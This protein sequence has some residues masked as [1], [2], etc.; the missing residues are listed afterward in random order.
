MSLAAASNASLSIQA[1]LYTRFEDKE[2]YVVATADPPDALGEQ[3]FK[4]IGYH[5]LP[6]KDVCGRVITLFLDNYRVVGVPVYIEGSQYSR[7]AFIFCICFVIDSLVV[8]ADMGLYRRLA[9]QLA[10]AFSALERDQELRFLSDDKHLPKVNETLVELRRQLNDP[11]STHVFVSIADSHSICFK[12]L[13]RPPIKKNV[14]E[15]K[16]YHVPYLLIDPATISAEVSA[17]VDALAIS[18]L[19]FIDGASCV[20]D[21]FGKFPFTS[22]SAVSIA[23]RLLAGLGS[24]F[25]LPPVDEFSRFCLTPEAATFFAG[26]LSDRAE[27]SDF[28]GVSAHEVARS[29]AKLKGQTFSAF[30][31]Q[32]AGKPRKL[33]IFGLIKNLVRAKNM[34]PYCVS[35]GSEILSA[36]TGHVSADEICL[37]LGIS[38]S[39]FF[40][41]VNG[42]PAVSQIWI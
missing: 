17:E 3:Q 6:D 11:R 22:P 14:P 42:Y 19:S 16:P 23:L 9:E 10:N 2:G 28:C 8:Q 32:V 18:V 33:I 40:N 15:V 20:Q 13:G 29:L 4:E 5:F 38:R 31:A 41:H 24:I 7:K 30:S 35:G 27:A 25:L 34:R 39:H 26:G 12:P 21:I 1:L 36:C 37:M